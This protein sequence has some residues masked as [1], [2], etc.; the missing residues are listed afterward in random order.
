MRLRFRGRECECAVPPA[1]GAC[2]RLALLQ[3][4]EWKSDPAII[5]SEC[6]RDEAAGLPEE[7][8]FQTKLFVTDLPRRGGL[9]AEVREL[10]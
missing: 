9:K 6:A 2:N 1:N 8:G 5:S 10:Y 3:V 4:V 7:G